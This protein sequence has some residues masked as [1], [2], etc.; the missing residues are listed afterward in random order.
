M[1]KSNLFLIAFLFACH[2][3]FFAQ[4]NKTAK[5]TPPSDA[6]S[7]F[8]YDFDLTQN[9]I[10]DGLTNPNESNKEVQIFVSEK[11]FPAY[12]KGDKIDAA[13]REKLRIWMEKNPDLIINTLK[14]RTNI[15]KPF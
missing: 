5:Q 6:P 8:T 1:K 4:Q 11:T 7:G 12:E 13:Y 10:V 15:V 2:I 14:H 3:S 9:L